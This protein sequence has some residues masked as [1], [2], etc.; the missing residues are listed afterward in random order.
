[1]IDPQ[2]KAS[3]ALVFITVANLILGA[4]MVH[5]VLSVPVGMTLAF[6]SMAVI[7][8]VSVKFLMGSEKPWR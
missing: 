1:M 7:W 4:L 8:C 3:I 6:G 2:T 5:E